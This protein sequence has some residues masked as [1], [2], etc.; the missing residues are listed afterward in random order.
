MSE[1]SSGAGRALAVAGLAIA[2]VLVVVVGIMQMTFGCFMVTD[3]ACPAEATAEA[4]PYFV[5]R[6]DG[7][8]PETAV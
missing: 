2:G 6:D 8:A 1:R 4:V 7:A 5:M 3:P